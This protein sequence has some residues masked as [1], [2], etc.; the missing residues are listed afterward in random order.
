LVARIENG[1]FQREMRGEKS[2]GEQAI[3]IDRKALQI[4]RDTRSDEISDEH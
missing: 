4:E 3:D 2:D 1:K